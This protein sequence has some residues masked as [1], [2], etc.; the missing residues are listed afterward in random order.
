M[1]RKLVL[2][3]IAGQPETEEAKRLMREDLPGFQCEVVRC[4]PSMD[5][6]FLT[7]FLRYGR[8]PYF[9]ISAIR[10]F[11]KVRSASACHTS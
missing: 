1:P 3:V 5:E 9:G 11:V 2:F 10:S 7:P 8:H 6:L 4:P